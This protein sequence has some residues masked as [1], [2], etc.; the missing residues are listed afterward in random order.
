MAPKKPVKPTKLQQ[1]AAQK[2]K[3][4]TGPKGSK[5]QGTTTN[6]VRTQGGTTM[7]KPAPSAGRRINPKAAKPKPAAKPAASPRAITNGGSATMKQI[8]AK[9]VQARRQA[10]GKPVRGGTKGRALTLPN[11]AKAG[12]NLIKEGAQRMRNL[13]DSGQV[14]AGQASGKKAVEAAKRSRARAA[15]GVGKGIKA[16]GGLRA[17]APAAVAMETLKARPTAAGT[18]TSALKRGDYKPRQG[19][20]VPKRLTQ[21]G[22]DKGSFDSAFKAS[23]AAGKKTFSWKGKKYTTKRKDD[24]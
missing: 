10:E 18:L 7:S 17:L 8:R 2:N 11:S 23:R 15:A 13:A 16:P 4:L 12:K 1:K 22:L 6:R 19:P 21:G 9:A 24:K 5:P 14:R 20:S 3:V